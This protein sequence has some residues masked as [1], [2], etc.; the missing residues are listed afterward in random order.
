MN[1][2]RPPLPSHLNYQFTN[3]WFDDNSR[4]VWDEF[5]P[6]LMPQRILEIGAYEGAASC[7]LIDVLSRQQSL[8]LHCIDT[9]EGSLEHQASGI[10]MQAVEQR[11]LTNIGIA[12]IRSPHPTR[13][14]VHKGRSDRELAG[15]VHDG[16]QGYFD[17]IFVDGSHMASDVLLD[18]LLG[19]RLLRVGG[20]MAFDDYLWSDQ[21]QGQPNLLRTPKIA[22]DSFTNIYSGKLKLL[23]KHL[24]Q[25]YIEKI[26]D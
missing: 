5:I 2:S 11:F 18:A 23:P 26:S 20:I 25:I 1:P 3:R 22:I 4:G 19:F 14:F 9:W 6:K 12:K 16:K 13:V 15:M 17:F 21:P 10:D 7:Y 8:E 24:Y